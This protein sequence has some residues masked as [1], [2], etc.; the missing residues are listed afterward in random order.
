MILRPTP[1][2]RRMAGYALIVGRQLELSHDALVTLE[3]AVFLHDIG[4]IHIS[5]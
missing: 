3:Q 4:T 2:C 5:D 1:H